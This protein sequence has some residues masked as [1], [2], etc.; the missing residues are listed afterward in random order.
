MRMSTKPSTTT[1]HRHSPAPSRRDAEAKARIAARKSHPAIYGG[2]SLLSV[3]SPTIG[4]TIDG[5]L[6]RER[7]IPPAHPGIRGGDSRPRQ[8]GAE[9]AGREP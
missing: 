2:V 1:F 5:D 9:G 6:R 4:R 3:M 7:E 8:G